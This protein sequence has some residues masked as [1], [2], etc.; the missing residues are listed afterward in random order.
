MNEDDNNEVR[1]QGNTVQDRPPNF[2]EEGYLFLVRC[3]ACEPERGKE[4]YA[5][6]VS[7]GHCAWCGWGA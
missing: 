2:R 7:L 6:A 4:N 5:F 3:F 1:N